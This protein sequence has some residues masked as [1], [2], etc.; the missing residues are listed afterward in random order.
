MEIT[1][2]AFS[3]RGESGIVKI[4]SD[5][6]FDPEYDGL[7]YADRSECDL[8]V[9]SNGFRVNKV[10]VLGMPDVIAFLRAVARIAAGDAGRVALGS[11]DAEISLEFVREGAACRVECAMSDER[12]GKEN[13]IRVKYPIE[14]EYQRDLSRELAKLLKGSAKAL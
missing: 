12:E 7:A 8:I 4:V 1:R 6:V 10:I 13:S 5:S 14:P 2:N 3:L 9:E 11:G